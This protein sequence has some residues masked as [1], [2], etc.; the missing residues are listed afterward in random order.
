MTRSIDVYPTLAG[1][2]GFELPEG[3]G[4]QGVDLSPALRG[5]EQAPELAAPSHTTLLVR[6]VYERMS[7]PKHAHNWGLVQRSYPDEQAQHMWVALREG[8]RFTRWKKRPDGKWAFES[9]DLGADS[10]RAWQAVDP[11][12]PSQA[13]TLERLRQYK[14]RLVAAHARAQAGETLLPAADEVE[15][16]QGL[17][18]IE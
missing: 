12:D 14:A 11:E 7:D 5:E 3:R 18:Y 15:A 2:A 1:L 9:L 10:S 8:D 16:L 13:A 4:I 17:G 6:S